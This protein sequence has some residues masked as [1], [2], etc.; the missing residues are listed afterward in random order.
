PRRRRR[1]GR[2]GSRRRRTARCP[3]RAAACP[4]PTRRAAGPA[5]RPARAGPRRRRS[6]GSGHAGRAAR[7]RPRRRRRPGRRQGVTG[8]PAPTYRVRCVAHVHSRPSDGTATVPE[9]RAAV[10]A[11]GAEVLL[12]TDHDS[13]GARDAGE[14]GWGD[15]VLVVA[16]HEVSPRGGHLLV[17]GTDE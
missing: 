8:T 3:A 12:L 7:R 4:P 11:A 14:D 6:A 16:G 15:G 13:L 1:A 5:T 17:F 10:R 9:L 2:T